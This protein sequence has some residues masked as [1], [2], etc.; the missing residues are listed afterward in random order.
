MPSPTAQYSN[1][2]KM[3]LRVGQRTLI[4]VTVFF[5][6]LIFIIS[7]SFLFN[8]HIIKHVTVSLY[9]FHVNFTIISRLRLTTC[10]KA[11]CLLLLLSSLMSILFQ[12]TVTSYPFQLRLTSPY[13]ENL[14]T[15]SPV[16][17]RQTKYINNNIPNL[18][19][20][21]SDYFFKIKNVQ[22][23]FKMF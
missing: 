19:F 4:T 8:A 14:K 2:K 10:V 6:L 9:M 11:D 21:A 23:S 3:K 7:N 16:T 22:R 1:Y 13:K 5:C 18:E 12:L 15:S 17:N 20:T